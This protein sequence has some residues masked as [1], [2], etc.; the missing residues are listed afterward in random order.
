MKKTK[1]YL[2]ALLAFGIGLQSHAQIGG[3]YLFE[4]LRLD[5]SARITALGGNLIT[6]KD[7]DI[8]LALKNPASLDSTN[9]GSITFQ[10]NFYLSD[11]QSG[12]V[13]YG[14][15]LAN[16]RYTLHAGIQYVNYGDFKETDVIGNVTG[17]F[18]AGE[19]A[20]VIGLGSQ[21]NENYSVGINLKYVNSRL[22]AYTASA[23]AVDIAGM[24]VHPKSRFSAS[25]VINNI[26]TVL[27]Q[28]T[29][30]TEGELPLFIQL[31]ISKRLKHLPF[32]Y[33][34]IF[35]HLDE[36]NIAYDDP[37]VSDNTVLFGE[38]DSGDDGP[39]FADVLF[40]HI[41]FNGEFLFGKKEN[42]R[43]RV[44]YNHLRRRELN[45]E[46]RFTLSGFSLGVGFKVN[47]FKID[48]GYSGYHYS[49]GAHFFG[50]STALSEF[51]GK[52][53]I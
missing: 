9:H 37:N 48:Y 36:W 6:V 19:Q 18:D 17:D 33:S 12:Y 28:Y 32:R 25:L 52:R 35:H 13:G 30:Q 15:H 16:T 10:H 39:G 8:A 42:L 31:G 24:Y 14:H 20:Y 11:I 47:R 1:Y 5:N 44:G 7:D 38:E 50:I 40:R 3:R 34:I 41:I 46:D 49:N 21:L 26:G 51:N 27:Q 22:E 23:F 29:E 4:F 43:L 45:L 53:K 2:L